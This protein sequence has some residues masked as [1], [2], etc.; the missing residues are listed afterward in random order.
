[1][2]P[3]FS[4]TGTTTDLG[5]VSSQGINWGQVISTALQAASNAYVATLRAD[6]GITPSMYSVSS[7]CPAGYYRQTV[8][9]PCV[10]IPGTSGTL[11]GISSTTLLLL[12]GGV[13]LAVVLLTR[14]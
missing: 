4:G 7:P 6:Q 1:M 8:N 3:E 12:A 5:A 2:W 11:G 9:G 10:P 14:K 13:L